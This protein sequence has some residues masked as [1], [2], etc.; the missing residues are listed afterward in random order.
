MD[1]EVIKKIKDLVKKYPNDADLGREVR[2]FLNHEEKESNPEKSK[3][4]W[5]STNGY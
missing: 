1:Y 3:Q 2:K 5:D 4:Q